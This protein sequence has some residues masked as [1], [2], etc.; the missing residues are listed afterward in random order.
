MIKNIFLQQ[1][2]HAAYLVLLP[3]YACAA[4]SDVQRMDELINSYVANKQ[5]TGTV[6]IAKGDEILLSKGYGAASIA[7]NI[8]NSPATK[9]R[10]AS[11]S[12]QF[13]AAA[14]LLLAEDGK[15]A[16]DDSVARH[17][18]HAPAT[19]RPVTLFQLL[20]HTSGMGDYHAY[21]EYAESTPRTSEQLMAMIRKHPLES[22]PGKRFAYSNSGYATLGAVIEKVSGLSYCKFMQDRVFTP[23]SMHDTGCDA[24]ADV[25]AGRASGYVNERGRMSNAPHYDMGEMFA[26]G[27]LYSTVGDMRRWQEALYNGK[28]LSAGSLEMMTTPH[29]PAYGLGLEVESAPAETVYGHGGHLNGFT[30]RISYRPRDGLH[31]IVLS[32]MGMGYAS[33]L[34]SKLRSVASGEAVILNSERT[35]MIVATH[36]LARRVGNYQFPG[37]IVSIKVDGERLLFKLGDQDWLILTAES[38][39]KFFTK[40]IDAQFEFVRTAKGPESLILHQNGRQI[41]MP[42]IACASC[43]RAP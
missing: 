7:W 18:P 42:R 17:L 39:S 16:L 19:W 34:G 12:K 22:R 20:A 38:D 41:V 30:S 36:I 23:L 32:N 26:D 28:L 1:L 35:A 10:I 6:L 3:I 9:F 8:P 2:L 13:T 40:D 27:G 14:I 4:Q 25:I 33:G 43:P 37:E 21:A 31:V 5:F 24:N 15:L 29:T 11:V